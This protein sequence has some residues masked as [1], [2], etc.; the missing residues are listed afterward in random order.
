MRLN[1]DDSR[2]VDAAKAAGLREPAVRF[3]YAVVV[4]ASTDAWL[5][6]AGHVLWGLAGAATGCYGLAAA[7]VLREEG[8][9]TAAA[10]GRHVYAL[11]D[12]GVFLTTEEGPMAYASGGA[13]RRLRDFLAYAAARYL[14]AL[15]PAD[16]A[17]R[18]EVCRAAQA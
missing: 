13:E 10:V 16:G 15:R 18:L 2:I 4:G 11:V 3:V 1:L 14:A 6:P 9:E 12:V 7:A 17:F 8:L 5:P